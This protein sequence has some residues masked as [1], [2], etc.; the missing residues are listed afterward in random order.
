M[1]QHTPELKNSYGDDWY[2]F[3]IFREINMKPCRKEESVFILQNQNP[4]WSAQLLW[5][6]RLRQAS[7]SLCDVKAITGTEPT[8]FTARDFISPKSSPLSGC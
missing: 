8:P 1:H 3:I 4:F 2:V 7:G 6:W 5:A